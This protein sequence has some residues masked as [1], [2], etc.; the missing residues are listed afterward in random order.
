MWWAVAAATGGGNGNDWGTEG[1]ELF[2][3]VVVVGV[4]LTFFFST[5]AGIDGERAGINDKDDDGD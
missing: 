5:R 3:G 4:K 1:P 2:E